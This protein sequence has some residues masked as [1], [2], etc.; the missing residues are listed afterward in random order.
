MLPGL[1]HKTMRQIRR[2]G[3]LAVHVGSSCEIAA[4]LL[5]WWG[6]GIPASDEIKQAVTSGSTRPAPF[7][8]HPLGNGQGTLSRLGILHPSTGNSLHQAALRPSTSA[9]LTIR[10]RELD[11]SWSSSRPQPSSSASTARA[12]PAIFYHLHKSGVTCPSGIAQRPSANC[13]QQRH[14]SNTVLDINFWPFHFPKKPSDTSDNHA[15]NS[16]QH[17]LRLGAFC[18]G[19][20]WPPR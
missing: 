13:K 9:L 15:A 12:L 3:L 8:L 10:A 4:L 1:V 7:R 16:S 18:S 2:S 14:N 11:A 20:Q 5:E 19:G 17:V 6:T